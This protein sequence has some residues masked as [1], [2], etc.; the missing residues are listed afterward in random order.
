MRMCGCLV[1]CRDACASLPVQTTS[2]SFSA[3]SWRCSRGQAEPDV[4]NKRCCMSNF[5][6]ALLRLSQLTRSVMR[7]GCL[8]F[9]YRLVTCHMLHGL[10]SADFGKMIMWSPSPKP[11]LGHRNVVSSTNNHAVA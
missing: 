1:G 3:V 7:L 10:N 5:R 8:D 9:Y 6:A 4:K 11:C 2:A